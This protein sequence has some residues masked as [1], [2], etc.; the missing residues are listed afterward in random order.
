MTCLF[1]GSELFVLYVR[2]TFR[3]FFVACFFFIRQSELCTRFD[4]QAYPTI[5]F[6]PPKG[7]ENDHG[8]QRLK[9]FEKA[10]DVMKF[11]NDRLGKYEP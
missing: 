5:L 6:G 11:I 3:V 1:E 9:A 8:L 7:Y 10:V 4:I 2:T